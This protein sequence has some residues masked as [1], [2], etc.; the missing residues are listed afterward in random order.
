[1]SDNP[2]LTMLKTH[3]TR[4]FLEGIAYPN[5]LNTKSDDPK[6]VELAAKVLSL[7]NDSEMAELELYAYLNR[8]VT[9]GQS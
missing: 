9:G 4:R 7:R 8:E 6:V 3:Y 1:M 5:Y 2:Y